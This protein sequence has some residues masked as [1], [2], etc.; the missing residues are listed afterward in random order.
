MSERPNACL[1]TRLSHLCTAVVLFVLLFAGLRIAF[2]F[3]AIRRYLDRRA[4]DG[5]ADLYTSELHERVITAA[6]SGIWLGLIVAAGLWAF[7]RNLKAR[8]PLAGRALSTNGKSLGQSLWDARAPIIVTCI[9][10]LAIRRPYLQLPMRFDESY[11]WLNY[12]TSPIYVT[13]S[14]YDSPNNHILHSLLEWISIRLLGSGLWA[15]RLPALLCGIGTAGMAAWWGTRR[16]SPWAGCVAGLL[17]ACSSPL[18]EYSV[19]ARGYTLS[20]FLLVSIW[21]LLDEWE[22][23]PSRVLLAAM[24]ILGALAMWAIPVSLYGLMVLG[25]VAWRIAATRPIN[26]R[27]R[28]WLHLVLAGAGAVGLT[29][30]LY[31][32][33][34][35]VWGASA[36]ASSGQGATTSYQEWGQALLQSASDTAALLFRDLPALVASVIVLAMVGATMVATPRTRS[37]AVGILLGLLACL[38][39]ITFQQVVPPPRTWLSLVPLLSCTGVAALWELPWL[40]TAESPSSVRNWRFVTLLSLVLAGAV[41]PASRM[42]STRSIEQSREAAKCDSAESIIREIAPQLNADEPIIAV[43]PTSAPL[44]LHARRQGL[45]EKHFYP[46]G[47]GAARQTAFLVVSRNPD[48]SEAS[49]LKELK[50]EELYRDHRSKLHSEWPDARVYRLSPQ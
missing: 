7:R 21:L 24:A 41:T 50:L 29:L 37:S 38:A 35:V 17:V 9:V 46:P 32:P 12:A 40:R 11:T 3:G 45:S 30:L 25:A 31:T 6:T 42:V 19:N 14:K 1:M 22:Q 16:C 44:A 43:T 4:G 23:R 2:P 47:R 27:W 48:Q 15:I 33:V 28:L 39:V 10:A 8:L 49:V 5:S 26:D 20:H 34:I 36:I 18:I 13:V